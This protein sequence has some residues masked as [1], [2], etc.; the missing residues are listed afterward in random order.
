MKLKMQPARLVT[1]DLRKVKPPPKEAARFYLSKEWI[2]LVAEE[3]E[4]R[5]G[6]KARAH[7]EDPLCK[8]PHRR[9]IRLFGDHIKELRDGGAMLDP[10]NVMFR[11]GSCH[12]RK[13]IE[14]RARRAASSP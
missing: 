14:E 10:D 6:S 8:Y 1:S 11:C 3:I 2:A 9:G 13:T 5:F 7:C 4:R 12:T